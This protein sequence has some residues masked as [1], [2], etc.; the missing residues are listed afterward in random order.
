MKPGVCRAKLGVEAAKLQHLAR[1]YSLAANSPLLTDF[2]RSAILRGIE[3]ELADRDAARKCAFRFGSESQ[4][5]RATLE[6]KE[7]EIRALKIEISM[8]E[9][10]LKEALSKAGPLS[11]GSN[12]SD[13]GSYGR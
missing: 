8:L 2:E 13:G 11:N 9:E 1:V 10:A 5:L 4:M 6:D 7:H 3:A 12:N